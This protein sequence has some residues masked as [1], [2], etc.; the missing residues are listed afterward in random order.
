[1]IKLSYTKTNKVIKLIHQ[2]KPINLQ[3]TSS[4]RNLI[5]ENMV[6]GDKVFS[7]VTLWGVNGLKIK[8]KSCLINSKSLFFSTGAKK[9]QETKPNH[10]EATSV[11][12]F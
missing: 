11:S 6:V 7:G 3:P 1:M 4:M 12:S 10:V 9:N 2:R 5:A 8:K